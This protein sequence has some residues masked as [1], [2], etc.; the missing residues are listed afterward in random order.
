[1]TQFAFGLYFRAID[2][3]PKVY[4]NSATSIAFSNN[5][6]RVMWTSY[7]RVAKIWNTIMGN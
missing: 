5:G 2:T 6:N 1:M 7:N 3:R 4:R